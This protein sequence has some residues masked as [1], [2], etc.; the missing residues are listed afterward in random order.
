MIDFFDK[1]LIKKVVLKFKK[2]QGVVI[3][4]WGIGWM[5]EK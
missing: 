2:Y 4:I 3:K 1:I 5:F